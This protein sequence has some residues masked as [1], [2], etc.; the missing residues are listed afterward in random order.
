MTGNNFLKTNTTLRRYLLPPVTDEMIQKAEKHFDIKLPNSYISFLK[1]QNGGI[2]LKTRCPAPNATSW[3]SDHIE[4][5]GFFGI[6]DNTR[7][8]K[9]VYTTDFYI[10]EWGYPAIGIVIC[11]CPSAGHD[12]IF[13]DYSICGKDGEPRVVHIDQE[14]DYQI[15]VLAENFEEFIKK[16]Y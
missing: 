11:D 9:T 5:N 10:K 3:S 16:L 13:L 8:Y 7:E 14:W 2:P 1:K 12:L 4:I 15:T 6:S